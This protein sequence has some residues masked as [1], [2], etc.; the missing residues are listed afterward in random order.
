MLFRSARAR[1][2]DPRPHRLLAAHWLATSEGGKAAPHLEWLDAREQSTSVYATEL[3][4]IY[5]SG[6]DF[7]RAMPKAD[8]AVQVA[9]YDARTR[10]FAA[11]VALRAKDLDAAERH[12][13]A[14]VVLEPDR[15]VHAQRLEALLKMKQSEGR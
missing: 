1:P 12:I 2:V 10:E 6:G 11:T 8:R 13:R 4:R 14:L 9:P 3:S 7:T 15:P 5:A